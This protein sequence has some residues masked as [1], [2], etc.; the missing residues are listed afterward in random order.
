MHRAGRSVV[1]E[2]KGGVGFHLILDGEADVV[3]GGRTMAKLGPGDFFGEMTLIDGAPRSA[4]V[5]AATDVTTMVLSQWEFR[6]LVKANPE[7]AWRLIVHLTG[8]IREEQ[9]AAASLD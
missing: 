6:P 3:R 1:T 2:R 8:R 9:Q 4:S 5:I 7:M